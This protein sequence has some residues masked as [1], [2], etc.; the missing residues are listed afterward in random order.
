[1]KRLQFITRLAG[2]LSSAWLL[3]LVSSFK[4]RNKKL[5]KLYD[6]WI[7]GYVYYDGEQIE[8]HLFRGMEL[9]LHRESENI[10][11]RNAIAVY[12]GEYKLGYIPQVDNSV[13]A[14]MLDQRLPLKAMLAEFQPD[15]PTWKRI[16]IHVYIEQ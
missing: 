2:L 10:Y 11:D 3:P 9:R 5:Y 14:A 8:E 7:A 15:S 12:A 1:M 13:L 4:F 6:E 16:S